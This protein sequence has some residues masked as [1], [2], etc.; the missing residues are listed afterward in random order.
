M[1]IFFQQILCASLLVT[2]CKKSGVETQ[3]QPPVFTL[4]PSCSSPDITVV[5]NQVLIVG[6]LRWKADTVN[7][8][9]I[10]ELPDLPVTYKADSL[11]EV[12]IEVYDIEPDWLLLSKD[13]TEMNRVFYKI[14]ND[15]VV[16]YVL[17]PTFYSTGIVRVKLTF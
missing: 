13:G 12:F 6:C 11:K 1:K 9:M 7:N 17:S 14:K 3:S 8:S 10:L 5:S 2:A 16:L 4:K 15:K